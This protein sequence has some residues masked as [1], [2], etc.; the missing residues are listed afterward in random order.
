MATCSKSEAKQPIWATNNE[1][2]FIAYRLIDIASDH[3]V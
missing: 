2:I 1:L 3:S